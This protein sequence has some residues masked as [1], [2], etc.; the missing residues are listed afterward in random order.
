LNQVKELDH[1]II[2]NITNIAAQPIPHELQDIYDDIY[3][4]YIPVEAEANRPESDEYTPEEGD[5]L[6]ATKVLLPKDGLLVPAEVYLV[7]KGTSLV[8]Q[9]TPKSHTRYKNL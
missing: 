4:P 5:Q 3:Q 1:S 7:E 6:I 2:L 9:C 8:T